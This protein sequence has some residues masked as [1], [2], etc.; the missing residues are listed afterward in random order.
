MMHVADGSKPLPMTVD[1]VGFLL[2]R[3]GQDCA[4]LQYLRELTQNSIEAIQAVPEGKGQIVWDL[5]YY[6]L[7]FGGYHKLSIVDTG[8]GMT[9]PEM[10]EYINQ[11]SSSMHTQSY[12]TNYG[13]GAKVAALTRNPEGLIYQ[14]WKDG[15]GYMTILWRDPRTDEYGLQQQERPDGTYDHWLELSEDL[16]PELIQDHGTMV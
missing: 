14:S 16:K 2:D 1:K 10:V 3:L 6:L 7:D 4:P 12:E 15:V 13:V 9:G 8:V 5:D 11:L